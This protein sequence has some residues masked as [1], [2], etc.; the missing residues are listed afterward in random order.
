MHSQSPQ[1]DQFVALLV[2]S[3]AAL[4]GY[5]ASALPLP[6]DREDVFQDVCVVLW[7]KFSSYDSARPF[8][9]WALGIATLKL[10]ELWRSQRNRPMCVAPDLLDALSAKFATFASPGLLQAQEVALRKCLEDLP[11]NSKT[12][13]QQRYFDHQ[14][15]RSMA[16]ASGFTEMALYQTLSRLRRKLADCIQRKLGN[17]RSNKISSTSA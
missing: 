14:S 7:T 11:A 4:R 2:K 5:L 3:Q 1:E 16:E 13:V 8:T 9:P 15:V 10:K 6:T 12:L 17:S